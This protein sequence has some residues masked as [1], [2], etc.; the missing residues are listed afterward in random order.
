MQAQSTLPVFSHPNFHSV[1]DAVLNQEIARVDRI[2][3]QADAYT[4]RMEFWRIREPE[5][6]ACCADQ[7]HE[8]ATVEELATGLEY[9]ERHFEE[10]ARG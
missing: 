1:L 8:R 7:C 2:L 10:A 6:V 4:K 9:C 5:L 3:A